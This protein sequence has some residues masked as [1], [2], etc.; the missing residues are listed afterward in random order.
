MVSSSIAPRFGL[1]VLGMLCFVSFI[2]SSLRDR[3]SHGYT[4]SP[5]HSRGYTCSELQAQCEVGKQSQD[6]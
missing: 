1:I 4:K 5:W 2:S 3:K 6:D